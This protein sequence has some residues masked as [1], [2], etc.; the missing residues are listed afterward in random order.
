MTTVQTNLRNT[1]EAADQI[2]YRPT[3]DVPAT[4][5]QRAIDQVGEDVATVIASANI[6]EVN[7]AGA[8]TVT[9]ADGIVLIN[10]TVGA[11][12][13]V[14]L[15]AASTVDHPI[16]IK[17]MKL[18]AATNNI[19]ITPDAVDV[20]GIDGMANL[21]ISNDGGAFR[22]IPTPFGWAIG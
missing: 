3:T 5:V 6:R 22:L 1:R 8:V 9:N 16:T 19:T 21:V 17:D 15:P 11:A 7:A 13:A 12:T 20:N 10:K 14:N 4:D 18:D 2:R